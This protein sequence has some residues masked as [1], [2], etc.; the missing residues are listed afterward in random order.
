MEGEW[1][2]SNTLQTMSVLTATK[3]G[4]ERVVWLEGVFLAEGRENGEFC[5]QAWVVLHLDAQELSFYAPEVILKSNTQYNFQGAAWSSH[6]A[7]DC[8]Y[9]Q[10]NSTIL[11]K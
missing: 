6:L 1:Q 5:V 7:D 9:R 3:K 4:G 2:V 8:R 11:H 10:A